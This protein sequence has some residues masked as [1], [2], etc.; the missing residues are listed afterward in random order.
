WGEVQADDPAQ[1]I[2]NWEQLKKKER[3]AKGNER[4]SLLDGVPRALP[5]L[6]QAFRYQERAARVG[7]DWPD[8]APV[9][10]KVEE[11][12]AEIDAAETPDHLA[13]E[14][15]DLLFALVNW[16]RWLGVEPESALRGANTRFYRRFRHIERA[17]A[18]QG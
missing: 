17:A 1:V 15:G 3:K 6:D 2:V 12:L 16:A 9:R 18:A 13:A 11:E 7:F 10:A 8:I 14:V 4:A 5:A